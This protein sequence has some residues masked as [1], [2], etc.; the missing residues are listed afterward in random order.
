M[1]IKNMSI[2]ELTIEHIENLY[3]IF[4]ETCG[5]YRKTLSEHI[6]N[7]RVS[8]YEPR[9][10]ESQQKQ[11]LKED[12]RALKE[13]RYLENRVE[14][15][16]EKNSRLIIKESKKGFLKVNFKPNFQEDMECGSIYADAESGKK[17]FNKKIREYFSSF[18]LSD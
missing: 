2:D 15:Q 7:G 9:K 11:V 16:W 14:S 5:S 6:I 10:L 13:N 1:K 17:E 18:S 8:T 4:T 3:R 12:L